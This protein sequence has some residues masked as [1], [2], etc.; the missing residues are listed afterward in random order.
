VT[1][2]TNSPAVIGDERPARQGVFVP[3]SKRSN[4]DDI[5]RMQNLLLKR[6]R[7][8][9]D[10]RGMTPEAAS[11]RAG[12]D[13]TFLR[14]AFERNG[15][16]RAENL[17]AIA[18]ALD[19]TTEELLRDDEAPRQPVRSGEVR[20]ADVRVPA[21]ADMPNDVPVLGTAAGSHIGGAF[22]FEGGVIDYVRRPPALI[23]AAQ[24]YALY[25]EGT[26]MVPEHNPGDLRFIHPGRPPRIGDSVVV[27]IRLQADSEIE[28]TIGRLIRKTE[29][30][31]AIG[32]LNP[33]AT[34]E[35]KRETV[36]AVHKVLTLNDLFGV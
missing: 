8:H 21:R 33:Q 3:L 27:Q 19:T 7:E 13:K 18:E 29:K 32:K 2:P 28:A 5:P 14:K 11:R 20:L 24:A 30:V 25:V 1:V 17:A 10:A 36:V 12:L 23:G 16:M 6:I 35:L 34:V 31:V 15:S 26:S 4:G 22:Q 9:L